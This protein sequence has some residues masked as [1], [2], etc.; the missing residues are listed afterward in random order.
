MKKKKQR[1]ELTES[2][3]IT[4]LLQLTLKEK[5]ELKIGK[6]KRT[7]DPKMQKRIWLK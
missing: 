1:F 3:S 2:K 5:L 4:Q 6:T 7:I